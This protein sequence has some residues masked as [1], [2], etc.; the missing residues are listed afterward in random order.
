MKVTLLMVTSLD[1]RTTK[2][3]EHNVL[4]WTSKEDQ[5]HFL[6]TIKNGTSFI[7]GKTTYEKTQKIIKSNVGPTYVVLV[8]NPGEYAKDPS[9]TIEFTNSDPVE[10]VQK[11]SEKGYSQTYLLGGETTNSAFFK[12]KLVDEI[13]ITV[14]PVIFGTGKGLSLESVDVK[15]KLD[16]M[17]RINERGTLLLAYKVLYS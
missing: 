3:D 15:L 11:L 4:A 2:W 5:E 13:Q 9:G 16:D 10:I 17:R 12:E 14:E 8:P 1:G 7:M 6:E